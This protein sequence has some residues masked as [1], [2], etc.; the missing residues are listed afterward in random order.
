MQKTKILSI[1]GSYGNLNEVE[2]TLPSVIEE[3][4]RN[5][6]RLIIHDSTE[7]E[8]GREE[9]WAYLRQFEQ[10][11]R[12]FLLLSNNLSMA[13]ARNMCLRLG[14]EMYL[15][16][17]I[18]M[19]ED[20]H[21]YKAGFIPKLVDAIEENYGKVAPNGLR[22]GLFTGCT[23]TKHDHGRVTEPF[24]DSGHH[25]V[26][27][28]DQ[29]NPF[30]VGGANS[31]FRAAP[32][33]HWDHVLKGYDTDEYLIST[34]QTKN[35]NYRNYHSGFTTMIVADGDFM[36]DV[37]VNTGRGTSRQIGEQALWD[38]KYTASDPRSSYRGKP[39]STMPDP[40]LQV[41]TES[42]AEPKK[43][44]WIDKLV[45]LPKKGGRID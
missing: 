12:V 6:A 24:G 43:K 8:H 16:D 14:Q 11:D 3:T 26:K 31:C 36:F 22:F 13:H 1:Y 42:K 20:D 32:T 45:S 40:S 5:D 18:A 38:D 19:M 10:E 9:K 35:L 44:N 41:P 39:H 28:T 34:F 37:E 29:A 2:Q 17:H 25:Y 4:Q 27:I 23:N 15:P 30:A 7:P 33:H 21:G